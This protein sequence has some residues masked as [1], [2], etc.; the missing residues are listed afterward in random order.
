M[1]GGIDSTMQ[2]L[3]PTLIK[4]HFLAPQFVGS[5]SSARNAIRVMLGAPS[6]GGVVQLDGV[7]KKGVINEL[8]FKAYGCP[9]TIGLMSWV[10]SHLQG[11][12]VEKIHQLNAQFL[13]ETLMLPREKAHCA[14][15]AEDLLVQF[16]GLA[17]AQCEETL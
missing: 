11:Q 2:D 9:Y 17:N 10:T 6:T 4:Q 16:I 5:F 14:L 13:M 3:L 8:V 7:V 12:P 1:H 15:L